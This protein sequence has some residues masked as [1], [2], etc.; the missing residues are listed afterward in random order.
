M[1]IAGYASTVKVSGTPVSM[2]GEA[3]TSI[4]YQTFQIIAAAR[5]LVD[6][7]Q[8]VTVKDNGTTIA[9]TLWSFNYITGTV[10]FS[11]GYIATGP[12]TIDGYYLPVAAI[13]EVKS[14]NLSVKPNLLDSTSFDSGGA[15]A[16]KAGL[17]TCS[18]SFAFLSLATADLDTG[19]GGDQSLHA[20]LENATP[21]LLEFG[22]GS[23]ASYFRAWALLSGVEEKADVNGLVEGTSNFELAP[24]GAGASFALT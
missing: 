13:L 15:V 19:T 17:V 21:K 5:R 18:G 1:A 11:S 12:V 24:Q 8:A 23:A 20:F 6:P 10:V 14:F 9:S 3:C 7:A 4:A 2:T 22:L 16:K